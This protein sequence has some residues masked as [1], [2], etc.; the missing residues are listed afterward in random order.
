MFSLSTSKA[1]SVENW[2]AHAV[3]RQWVE[4]LFEVMAGTYGARFA[5]LW[6]GAASEV[7]LREWGIGLSKVTT[8]QIKAGAVNL[9]RLVKAPTLPEFLAHCRSMR[10]EAAAAACPA[11]GAAVAVSPERMAE[12]RARLKGAL[13]GL[14]VLGSAL[15][16]FQVMK[17]QQAGGALPYE[18]ERCAVVAIRSPAGRQVIA[19]CRDP[20]LRQEYQNLYDGCAATEGVTQEFE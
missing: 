15:W 17:R 13:S 1:A 2:P 16:A 3:P 18:V 8:E 6:G 9:D 4:R 11:L 19:N 10:A 5:D 14:P 7:V 12:N 20:G